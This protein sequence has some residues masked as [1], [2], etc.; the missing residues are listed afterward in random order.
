MFV[1]L[2][3]FSQSPNPTGISLS[4][5]V[6]VGCQSYEE[7]IRGDKDPIFIENIADNT[8][9]NVCEGSQVVYTLSGILATSPS[10]VWS[11]SGGSII[12]SSLNLC[13]VSWGNVGAGTLTF[14]AT[15]A[16]GLIT[17]TICFNKIIKP[18]ANFDILPITSAQNIYY[19][20]TNQTTFL[21]N[22]SNTAGGTGLFSYNWDFGDGTTS[23]AFEPTHIYTA[24][25]TYTII[26][27][28]TNSCYCTDTIKKTIKVGSVGFDISCPSVVCDSQSATYSL[29]FDGI[30]ICNNNYNW[31][32]LG[33][34]I[35][36]QSNGNLTVV[37][38]QVDNTGFGY[39]TF[40]P[41]NCNLQCSTPTTIKI[42]VIQTVG[43][44]IG[45]SN[46]CLGGQDRFKMPQWPTTDF[47]WEIVGNTAANNLGVLIHTDQRNEVIVEPKVAGTITL[48]VTYQ[49]TLLHCGG[50]AIFNINVV[51]SMNITGPDSLCRN[52]NA[53]Y[54][55][56]AGES[57]I[58]TLTRTGNLIATGAASNTFSYNFTQTGTYV[59]SVTGNALCPS[60][61]KTINVVAKPITPTGVTGDGISITCPNAPYTYTLPAAIAGN[62][63]RW[64]VPTGGIF[65][66]SNLGNSVSITFD[67]APTHQ[68]LV[69]NESLNPIVCQS[70]PLILN[71]ATQKI[72]VQINDGLSESICANSFVTYKANNFGTTTTYSAGETYIWSINPSIAGSITTGQNTNTVDVLWNNVSG[73][74]VSATISLVI[75][76]CTITSTPIIKTVT[77]NPV[78]AI[79]MT[80]SATNICSGLPISFTIAISNGVALL[81]GNI[82]NWDFGNG[83][84]TT[85]T[86]TATT[87]LSVPFTFINTSGNNAGY[88]VTAY[89]NN[90]NGCY[91]KTNIANKAVT[92]LPAPATSISVGPQGNVFC[93]SAGISVVLTASY[94]TGATIKWYKTG[95]TTVLG[96]AGNIVIIGAA[97]M[98]FGTYYF[99]ATN[100]A[101]CIATSNTVPVIQNCPTIGTCI[102]T[103]TPTINN[104]SSGS[105]G[106]I[107]LVGAAS[108]TPL[109]QWWD[110][111][112]PINYSNYTGSII[113]TIANPVL[114][115]IYNIFK[116]AVYTCTNGQSGAINAYKAVTIPYVADFTT[117]VVCN[118][119]NTTYDIKI[120]DK[121]NFFAPV[122]SRTFTYYIGNSATGPWGAPVGTTQNYTILNKAPGN[123]WV[124]QVITGNYLGMQPACEKII[125]VSI[126]ITLP[127]S[128]SFTPNPVKCNDSAVNF[129]IVNAS[130]LN[131]ENYL[132]TLD[133]GATNTLKEPK[134]VFNNSGLQQVSVLI[135]NKAGCTKTLTTTVNIP[136]KCFGGDT[137]SPNPSVCAGNPVTLQYTP[138]GDNC[139]VS[140]YTWMNGN[141]PIA[142]AAN[143]AT[144]IVN[145]DGF[146]WVKVKNSL[147]CEYSTSTR[148]KPVFKISPTLTF[149]AINSTCFGENVNLSI[150]S[151]ATIMRWT[152]DGVASPQYNDLATIAVPSLAVGS[153]TFTVTVTSNGCSV[154]DSKTTTVFPSPVVPTIAVTLVSCNPY[155]IN[156]TAN[157]S[158]GNFNWSNGMSGN[159]IV[160]TEGGPYKVTVS[161]G[162][163][164]NSVQINVPKNP[165][166]F[167]WVFPSG[168]F[169][170]CDSL[171]DNII[172]GPTVLLNS[173]DWFY[174]ATNVGTGSNFPQP[175]TLGLS[176]T[177]NLN[178][179]TGLCNKTSNNLNYNVIRCDKCPYEVTVKDIIK[180]DTAYCSAV[181]NLSIFNGSGAPHSVTVTS[182]GNHV[183]IAPSSFLANAGSGNYIF[184]LVPINGFTGGTIILILN[185]INKEGIPCQ[186]EFV[187]TVPNCAGANRKALKALSN[188]NTFKLVPNPAKDAVNIS[189]QDLATDSTIEIYDLTGRVMA[190]Y[191]VSKTANLTIDTS[192]YS[193][194]TYIVLVRSND[195][196]IIQKKLIK[197]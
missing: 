154:S 5:N 63:Y 86:T 127:Q 54:N 96:T 20:C 126:A 83:Y 133:A 173:W 1:S 111:V 48:K 120:I 188:N 25:G 33:G 72:D 88:N 191:P 100:A 147:N 130:L 135:T 158:A 139:A 142:G 194:G 18:I 61:P 8:C 125:A 69:Y 124:R 151:N 17:K 85:T 80:S 76:K 117:A 102:I 116:R 103:P 192:I 44:I 129:S 77:V 51:N 50:T 46:I 12:N 34:T 166:N 144:I 106:I 97:T 104:T 163:C 131:D 74:A 94:T 30:D 90:P 68:L 143:A 169:T 93:T 183:L 156:L 62:Q 52:T 78:A 31:S 193:F 4:W 137:T 155:K 28:V 118:T 181:L 66:G 190:L 16:T 179:N 35:A 185:G 98:G 47:Q 43:T 10:T 79:I 21:A 45:N 136:A 39:V 164:S 26:L 11:I 170:S 7:L 153:H 119:N 149:A 145:T 160:V 41:K 162:G 36:S 57:S 141:V 134:R 14:T 122:A 84:T 132:W 91:G 32:V 6:S 60:P 148:I 157:G 40:D 108:G 38:D 140:N 105:C 75:K 113:G 67:N 178:I 3:T 42:P 27:T 95:S 112:G 71:I 29:P 138:N 87:G 64:V 186:T 81:P 110:I 109:Q 107:N 2:L 171:V 22:L 161:S 150:V 180:G 177:Y 82:V 175:L 189:Y 53:N 197:N 24:S 101:G 159:S 92:I 15:A 19:S 176:G 65:N 123:Y 73:V 121:S 182:P 195:E 152:I 13:T 70:S 89:I 174:N 55:L 23:A 49:N 114:P 172:I 99:T 59:L 146:Y 115:G 37:W 196:I 165:D 167:L 187:V 128:I 9:I 58:W 56:P 184:S 168:C